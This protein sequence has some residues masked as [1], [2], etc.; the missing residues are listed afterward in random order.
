MK[1]KSENSYAHF[2]NNACQFFPCHSDADADSFNCLFCYCPLYMLGEACGGSFTY[3]EKGV[4]D[5]SDCLLPHSEGGYEHITSRFQKIIE[6]MKR[7]NNHSKK[8]RREF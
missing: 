2:S 6:T 5:C 8:N 1:K 7:N 3:N 4:K